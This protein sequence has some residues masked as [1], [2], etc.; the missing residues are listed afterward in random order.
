VTTLAG[1]AATLV[2]SYFSLVLM[3]LAADWFGAA[4]WSVFQQAL[5]PTILSVSAGLGALVSATFWAIARPDRSVGA[6]RT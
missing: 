3:L 2:F 5:A 6:Q 4:V 1:S